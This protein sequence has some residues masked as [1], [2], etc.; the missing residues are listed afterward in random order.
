MTPSAAP[1]GAGTGLLDGEVHARCAVLGLHASA[2]TADAAIAG[3]EAK[4]AELR[5]FEERSGLEAASR[6]VRP[7][8]R[9]SGGWPGRVGVPLLI[10]GLVAL[11]LGWAISI[12]ISNGLGR[13]F[14]TAWRDSLVDSLERQV[15][16][17]AQPKNEPAAA[18]QKRMVEAVR[19]LKARYGPVWDEIVAPATAPSGAR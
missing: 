18:Q 1:A 19:A 2:P 13:T 11:Q 4:L 3:L 16:L 15:L 7:A 14:T 8:S 9:R 10:G 6:L 5:A 12:G 17:L